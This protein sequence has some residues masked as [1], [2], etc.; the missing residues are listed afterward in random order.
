MSTKNPDR[1]VIVI[2]FEVSKKQLEDRA[3]GLGSQ[4]IDV[5]YGNADDGSED[6]LHLDISNASAEIDEWIRDEFGVEM[7]ATVLASGHE[8]L[9]EAKR[10]KS[11]VNALKRVLA[12]R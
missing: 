11:P 9:N 10:F 5:D 7:G 1:E 4:M 8:L 12:I 2:A 3:T 6:E